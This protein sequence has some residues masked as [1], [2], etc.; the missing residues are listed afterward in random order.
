[1]KLAPTPLAFKGRLLFLRI[2]LGMAFLA[3]LAGYFRVQV[4]H[5]QRYAAM[6][7]EYRVTKR[8]IKATRGLIYDRE[9]ELITRNMPTYNLVLLRDEMDQ[10]WAAMRSQLSA[11]L[12]VSAERLEKR[13]QK[14]TRLLS[15]PVLLL[16]D[17]NFQESL[18]I[19]RNQMRYPGLAIEIREKRHYRYGELFT[20]VLGYVRE[21]T[22]DML[23]ENP[24]LHMGDVV[25]QTG[26]E[27]TYDNLLTGVDGEKTI[28]ID[29]RGVYQQENVTVPPE[30]GQDLHLTLDF[31][32]Q[33]L[34]MEA[35]EGRGGSVVMMKV[36]TGEILVY[37]SAPTYDLNLFTGGLS[38]ERWQALLNA[39]DQPL[40]NRP[41]A[42]AYAPG[43]IF[44]VV[45]TLAALEHNKITPNTKYLCTG[46]FTLHNHT[47][48]CHKEEGHGL[49]DVSEAIQQ[50]CNVYFYNVARDLPVDD[51]A[52]MARSL[53]IGQKTG[54]DLTGEKPGLMPTTQWKE[55]AIGETWFPGETLSV[56]IGQGY[57]QVTPLQ[58][59]T[60][61]ATIAGEGQR[62]QPHLLLKSGKNGNYERFPIDTTQLD[63]IP[64]KHFELVKNAMWR[65]VNQNRGTG[66][67]AAIPGYDVCGKTGTAQLITFN[68]KAERE[69][70]NYK[71]AWFAGFAPR[72]NAEVA[73]IV[74][75]EQAGGGGDQAAPIA[76][77]LF[78]A[79]R[80]TQSQ[81]DPT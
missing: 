80:R 40:F 20:H 66:S 81:V 60:L 28:Y 34:A 39:P 70:D 24:R 55:R 78:E 27:L 18:R 62:P 51:L 11:F 23:R 4:M 42:G 2:L 44:K 76:K 65:V 37:I 32:L 64:A 9:G 47:S 13:Y 3:I 14:R 46:T 52:A 49:I 74:L 68:T 53:G 6:G 33:K 10:P 63:H 31:E 67:N 17:I 21:A 38:Q 79:Y 5:Q 22:R 35:M 69:N 19:K 8:R 1:M 77:R 36:D 57:L 29:H 72:D 59:V 7:E 45:T 71:N 61:M 58:L 48:R 15:Q 54:L 43:S 73:I 75:V 12:G 25:G 41:A 50:S 56:A 30:P 16:E 26:L